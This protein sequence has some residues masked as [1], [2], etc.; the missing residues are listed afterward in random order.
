MSRESWHPEAPPRLAT[1]VGT[2]VRLNVEA[3][4]DAL[5][6][7]ES[8]SPAFALCLWTSDDPDHLAPTDISLGLDSER[9]AMVAALSPSDA[10]DDV[11]NGTL[12]GHDS[13]ALDDPTSRF[14]DAATEVRDWLTRVDVAD[15]GRW[16][17]EETAAY[18]TRNPPPLPVTDDFVAYVFDQ[19]VDLVAGLRWIVPPEKQDLLEQKRLLVDDPDTLPGSADYE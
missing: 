14:G 6:R 4:R 5:T 15:A 11:W 17:L 13:L 1:A 10:F 18:L 12:Y 8:A 9:E 3:V 2:L 7:V 19:G 16:V